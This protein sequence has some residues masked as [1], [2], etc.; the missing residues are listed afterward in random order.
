[1][2][3]SAKDCAENQQL[4]RLL[5]RPERLWYVEFQKLKH[6]QTTAAYQSGFL[7]TLSFYISKQYN[8]YLP[9]SLYIKE[10]T[11]HKKFEILSGAVF[12]T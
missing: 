7:G 12:I 6:N 4:L 3:Y 10:Q 8:D 9:S 1:M 5:I 11:G 2:T